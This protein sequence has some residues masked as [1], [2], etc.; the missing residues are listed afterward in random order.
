MLYNTH[1]R[2]LIE[3]PKMMVSKKGS[4]CPKGPLLVF[5][6]CKF[7]IFAFE[8]KKHMPPSH[9]VF[10]L[11]SFGRAGYLT[12]NARASIMIHQITQDQPQL[13]LLDQT[14][15]E[16]FQTRFEPRFHSDIEPL[17]IGSERD[18]GGNFNSHISGV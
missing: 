14:P 3:T 12:R 1:L 9:H 16:P 15:R 2:K 5:M 7:S 17:L 8:N 13:W 18:I 11:H 6:D 10:F 4:P